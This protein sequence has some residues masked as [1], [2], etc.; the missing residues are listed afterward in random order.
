MP[1]WDIY[2]TARNAWVERTVSLIR[3]D[4]ERARRNLA[5]AFDTAW[6]HGYTCGQVG[7][8]EGEYHGPDA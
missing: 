7:D 5:Q 3:H 6:E 1:E 4:T 8:E 2:M